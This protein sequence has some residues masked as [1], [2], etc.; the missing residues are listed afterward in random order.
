MERFT[1]IILQYA[2]YAI[3]LIMFTVV[4]GI[5][6]W[7]SNIL[8]INPVH[9]VIMIVLLVGLYMASIPFYI[10]LFQAVKLLKC[11]E[12]NCAFSEASVNALKI[13]TRC[14]GAIFVICSVVGLPFFYYWADLDDAPGLIIIGLGISGIIFIVAVFASILERI[15]RE[16]FVAKSEN[17]LT[18]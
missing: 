14:I 7:A 5:T 12:T 6:W 9:T 2:V 15:F 1:T 16:A 11:I 17:D 18:I 4:S 10:A 8:A 3:G 13:I